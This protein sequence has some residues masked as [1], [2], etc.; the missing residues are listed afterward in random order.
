[1]ISRVYV[2]DTMLFAPKQS[3]FEEL[4]PALRQQDLEL[5]VGDIGW[6][7]R[8]PYGLECRKRYCNSHSEMS[9]AEKN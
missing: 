2:D 5:E 6:F 3:F 4:I 1:V 7:S 9:S 8:S